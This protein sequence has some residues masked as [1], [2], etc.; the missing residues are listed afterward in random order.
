[1]KGFFADSPALISSISARQFSRVASASTFLGMM[2]TR[3]KLT[4]AKAY[5]GLTKGQPGD[6]HQYFC[7]MLLEH[8]ASSLG[9][10]AA[11]GTN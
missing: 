8:I 7:G 9:R 4:W 2:K 5:M 6:L 11:S 3:P 10:Y 1:M